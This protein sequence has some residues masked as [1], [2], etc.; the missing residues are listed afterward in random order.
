MAKEAGRFVLLQVST[1]SPTGFVTL[2]GQQQTELAGGTESDDIT[3]KSHAGWAST[4][5]VLRRATV[6]SS[7]KADWP[8]AVG[9]DVIRAAWEAGGD[10]ECKLLLNAAGA[11]YRGAFQVTRFN[12]S[13][14]HTNATAYTLTL[15]NNGPLAYG[16]S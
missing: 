9:L 5:N 15:V 16:A 3:D 12:V 11:H 8:D 1:G 13:G 10:V 2:A 14:T 4:L 6:T 7:G